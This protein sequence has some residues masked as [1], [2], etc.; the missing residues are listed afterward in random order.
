MEQI[1]IPDFLEV[2]N[3]FLG[4]GLHLP[5]YF[6]FWENKDYIKQ[7]LNNKQAKQHDNKIFREN[8]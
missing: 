8:E 5:T 7:L 4:G 2:A 1:Y 6:D 3:I